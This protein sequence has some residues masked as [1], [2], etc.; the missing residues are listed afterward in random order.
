MITHQ[1]FM[2]ILRVERAR[3]DMKVSEFLRLISVSQGTYSTWKWRIR[4]GTGG[5]R[6]LT[7]EAVLAR[8]KQGETP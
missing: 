4:H 2:T 6:V 1:E 5:P 8:L 7:M 3:R